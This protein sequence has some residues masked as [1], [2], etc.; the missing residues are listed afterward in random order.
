MRRYDRDQF[1]HLD[2]S[3]RERDYD[4]AADD[5]WIGANERV[6]HGFTTRYESPWS[7]RGDWSARAFASSR[8]FDED[9]RQGREYGRDFGLGY[10]RDYDVRRDHERSRSEDY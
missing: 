9:R 10:G 6:P 2:D 4:R 7:T 1:R 5:A 8:A 3:E